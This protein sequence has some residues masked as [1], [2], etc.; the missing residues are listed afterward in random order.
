MKILIENSDDETKFFIINQLQIEAL[1]INT[2]ENLFE[3]FEMN[4]WWPK[5][6]D[7]KKNTMFQLGRELIFL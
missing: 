5:R 3:F 4:K 1:I 2:K 6:D 7:K